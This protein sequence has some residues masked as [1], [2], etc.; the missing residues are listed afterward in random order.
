VITKYYESS[1][2]RKGLGVLVALAAFHQHFS[3]HS[4][5][6]EIV[7]QRNLKSHFRWSLSVVMCFWQHAAWDPT[8]LANIQVY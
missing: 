3:I 1:H 8:L 5:N 6:S 7:G 4:G 2:L